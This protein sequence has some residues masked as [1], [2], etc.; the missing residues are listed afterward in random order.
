MLHAFGSLWRWRC[1]GW[2]SCIW[3]KFKA[4]FDVGFWWW[5]AARRYHRLC[6]GTG[7][8][9]WLRVWI[10][11][12]GYFPVYMGWVASQAK[13]T[14]LILNEQY[15]NFQVS[16]W[17]PSIR[18]KECR[19]TTEKMDRS[20]PMKRDKP[21]LGLY[22]VA[23]NVTDWTLRYMN[24]E[25]LRP[26]N[27]N[28][29]L[30]QPWESTLNNKLGKLRI[31]L[32]EGT[33]NSGVKCVFWEA[34]CHL[35]FGVIAWANLFSQKISLDIN[36]DTQDI[37]ISKYLS[38]YSPHSHVTVFLQGFGRWRAKRGCQKNRQGQGMCLV[39]RPVRFTVHSRSAP[40]LLAAVNK[41]TCQVAIGVSFISHQLCHR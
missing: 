41:A 2:W 3:M 29:V 31:L 21:E 27:D 5:C 30:G 7:V 11:A 16:I 40:A 13:D 22:P 32:G 10:A 38:P 23:G 36:V 33:D 8:L 37:C 17:I 26:N 35:K 1:V 15:S 39:C 34:V 25:R 28:V 19:A 4:Y 12:V 14:T 20:T 24:R 9:L 18:Q 6:C